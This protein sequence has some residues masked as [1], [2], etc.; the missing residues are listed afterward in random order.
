MN[1]LLFAYIGFMGFSILVCIAGILWYFISGR[2]EEL[3]ERPRRNY[4]LFSSPRHRSAKGRGKKI[5]VTVTF[6]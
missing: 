3:A 6:N 2:K 4:S 5:E 1:Q